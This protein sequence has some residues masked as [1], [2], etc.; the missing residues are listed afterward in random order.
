MKL[1]IAILLLFF[2]A[3][4]PPDK[5]KCCKDSMPLPNDQ[6]VRVKPNEVKERVVACSVPRLRPMFDGQATVIFQVQIDEEGNIRCARIIS[7]GQNAIMKAAA[8]EAA[9]EWRFK[10]LIVDG[11]AKPYVGILPLVVSWDTEKSGKQCPKEKR[12]A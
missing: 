3:S 9:K 5:W 2:Q 1:L 8:I 11:H 7:G 6:L 10:P 12:R 4:R